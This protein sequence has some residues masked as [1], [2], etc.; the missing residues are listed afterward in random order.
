MVLVPYKQVVRDLKM[1][2]HGCTKN[3][4]PF[5][6]RTLNQYGFQAVIYCVRD[7]DNWV[8]FNVVAITD[9]QTVIRRRPARRSL[10]RR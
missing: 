4:F 1:D 3:L 5:V 7:N 6:N 8:Q 10:D 2:L 9:R